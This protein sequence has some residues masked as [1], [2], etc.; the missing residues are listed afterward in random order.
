MDRR[1]KWRATWPT[2]L[3]RH[4]HEDE[5][6]PYRGLRLWH[7]W[8]RRL[9]DIRHLVPSVLSVLDHGIQLSY[10][11]EIV[12]IQECPDINIIWP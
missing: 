2:Q 3:R 10:K 5:N 1:Y 7:Y 6:H 4:Q 9:I 11:K 8:K 12:Q